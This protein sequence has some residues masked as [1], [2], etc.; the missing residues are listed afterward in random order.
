MAELSIGE[1]AARVRLRPSAIRYYEAAGLLPPPARRGGRRRYDG[2]S[3]R[4]LSF[5]VQARRAGLTIAKVRRWLAAWD[6]PPGAG[7]PLRDILAAELATL[8]A[9]SVEIERQ[10]AR[11]ATLLDCRCTS[12]ADCP[13][14]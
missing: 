13:S 4:R 8:D 9:R 12:I 1:L 11:V 14:L 5:I 6:A 10:R 7:S 2:A 3:L